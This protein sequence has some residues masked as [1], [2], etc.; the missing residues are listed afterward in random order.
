MQ[1]SA[2]TGG[3]YLGFGVL[4]AGALLLLPPAIDD[5]AFVCL[6]LCVATCVVGT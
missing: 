1:K 4:R 6:Q 3:S 5:A 2:L